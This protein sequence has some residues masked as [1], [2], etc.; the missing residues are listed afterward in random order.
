MILLRL[1]LYE[2][3]PVFS[4]QLQLFSEYTATVALRNLSKQWLFG[5]SLNKYP[6]KSRNIPR[7]IS[8]VESG[9]DKA[10]W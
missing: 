8:M 1:G 3:L 2:I 6:E 5:G 4:S 9:F 10:T 7:K